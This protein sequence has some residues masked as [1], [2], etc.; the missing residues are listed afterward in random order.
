MNPEKLPKRVLEAHIGE[1]ASGKSENAVN[2]ALDLAHL[3]RKV[4]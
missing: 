3:G 4:T 2:R 1:Y